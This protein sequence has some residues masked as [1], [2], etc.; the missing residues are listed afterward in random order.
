MNAEWTITSS[1]ICDDLMKIL[2]HKTHT[3]ALVSDAEVVTGASV[4]AKYFHNHHKIALDL[5]YQ[6]GYITHPLSASRFN[7][8]LHQL[9]HWLER[10]LE[11]LGKLYSTGAAFVM[12]EVPV[13]VCRKVRA[14][15]SEK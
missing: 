6:L 12:G 4:T 10:M 5:M 13:P 1:V 8:R 3:F 9:A 14:W 15:H 2:N 11:T 7:R